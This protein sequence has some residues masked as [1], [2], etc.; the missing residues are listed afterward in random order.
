MYNPF[1]RYTMNGSFNDEKFSS[2][3]KFKV[4]GGGLEKLVDGA[5]GG[6]GGGINERD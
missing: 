6:G 4:R 2:G 3:A 1:P 5:V